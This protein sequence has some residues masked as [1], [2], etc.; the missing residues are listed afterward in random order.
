MSDLE[1]KFKENPEN[2]AVFRELEH[3][4]QSQSQWEKL[5]GIYRERAEF[6]KE[7]DMRDAAA[8][9][10]KAGR[11]YQHHLR[12]F[13]QAY[14]LLRQ[15]V[16]LDVENDEIFTAI[17]D[18]CT[19]T[20]RWQD[21]F[22][23]YCDRLE[24]VEDR[25]A[26][27]ELL[28][29][30]AYLCERHLKQA[31]QA[32]L[33]YSR[34]RELEP[35]NLEIL[36]QLAVL[37]EKQDQ[38]NSAIEVW[39]TLLKMADTSDTRDRINLQ[40]GALWEKL[41]DRGRA[42]S[43]YRS[44][45]GANLEEEAFARL[46]HIY[47][48]SPNDLAL[49]LTERLDSVEDKAEKAR[50][51]KKLAKLQQNREAAI[52][53]YQR[54]LEVGS[55]DI[56]VL[57]EISR[58][59]WEKGQVD[60]WLEY[61]LRIVQHL[62]STG[63]RVEL[64][65]E[66]AEKLRERSDCR[67]Q[68]IKIYEA[69]LAAAPQDR[70]AVEE[71][72]RL[73][74]E[75]HNHEALMKILV[76]KSKNC[77]LTERVSTYFQ[78]AKLLSE[79][80]NQQ[81]EAKS[82]LQKVLEIQEDH[83]PTLDE[84]KEQYL[85]EGKSAELLEVLRKK[86]EIEP[87]QAAQYHWEMGGI[88]RDRL[89]DA[90]NAIASFE[91]A[92]AADPRFWA[93]YEALLPLLQS[94]GQWK[95]YVSVGED[96][97]LILKDAQQAI[98]LHLSIA[99]IC[100]RQEEWQS[101]EEHLLM[102]LRY[103]PA[104]VHALEKLEALYFQ[105]QRWQNYVEV[106]EAKA[107]FLAKNEELSG[108][109][110]EIA[111]VYR[112]RL[113]QADSALHFYEKAHALDPFREEVLL[114]MQDLAQQIG[115]KHNL[116]YCLT[117]RSRLAS[118]AD[119][120]ASLLGQLG[121][122]FTQQNDMEQAVHAYEQ[123]LAKKNDNLDA[124]DN[125]I[126]LYHRQNQTEKIFHLL[127]RK[128]RLAQEQDQRIEMYRELARLAKELRRLP[129]AISYLEKILSLCPDHSQVLD[130]IAGLYLEERMWS[131]LLVVYR[132]KL[133]Q[134][135][136]E[137]KMDILRKMAAIY[138]EHVQ[139]L[140]ELRSVYREI[141]EIAPADLPTLHALQ[142]L[143]RKIEDWQGLIAACEEEVKVCGDEMKK[144]QIY[145]EMGKIYHNHLPELEKA[146][147][148]YTRALEYDADNYAV[149]KELHHLYLAQRDY[150]RAVE[151]IDRQL[152][153]LADPE[154]EA[155]LLV[156]KGTLYRDR[157]NDVQS[158]TKSFQEALGR[159]PTFLEPIAALET[160]FR[161]EQDYHALL[162]LLESKQ[163]VVDE[164]EDLH[165][166]LEIARIYA[167]HLQDEGNAEQ[168][169]LKA[170]RQK[171]SHQ[172][173]RERLVAFYS[174]RQNWESS[175]SLYHQQID[176]LPAGKDK[177][178]L[179]FLLGKLY[180]EK[181][182]NETQAAALY[183]QVLNMDQGN[184]AAIK[185]LQKIY[186]KENR[187]PSLTEAYLA[188]LAIPDIPLK[189]RIALHLT[190]AEIFHQ[191]LDRRD[192]AL[193]H[194]HQA[195]KLEPGNLSAIRH[196]E[197]LYREL[198]DYRALSQMLLT[199]LGI[200][201]NEKRLL[202]IHLDLAEL[203]LSHLK[204]P[205]EAIKHLAKAHTYRMQDEEILAKL[206]RVLYERE[207]WDQY[208]KYLMEELQ[209][210]K[211]TERQR[212]HLELAQIY[213]EKLQS[214]SKAIENLEA[215]ILADRVDTCYLRRLE[216]LYTKEG[217]TRNAAKLVQIYER[218]KSLTVDKTRLIEIY[219]QLGHL[220]GQE[221]GDLDKAC[222]C[223]EELLKLERD[224]RD[225]AEILAKIY[226]K[227]EKWE[228]LAQLL[229]HEAG[230]ATD[231]EKEKMLTKVGNI[232]EK[233]IKDYPKAIGYYQ[234]VL[235]L[236]RANLQALQGMRRLAEQ[237]KDWQTVLDLLY[238][239]TPLCSG[240]EQAAVYLKIA[241]LWESRFNL[242]H[243]AVQSYLEMLKIHFYHP[244][245]EYVLSLLTSIKDYKTF[246][247][248]SQKVIKRTKDPLQK[249]DRLCEL[250][251]VLFYELKEPAQAV[252][253][254][255]KAI[256]YSPKKIDA[257]S[258]L[259]EIYESRQQ[260]QEL[261]SCKERKLELTNN[262]TEIRKLHWDLGKI[263]QERLFDE[264]KA[265]FHYE[266]VLEL[267]P[268]EV[269][270][271]H[272]L[273]QLYLAWGY[274]DRYIQLC[275]REM[276]IT[277]DRERHIHL[278]S[279]I[280]RSWEEKLY[281]EE[282]AIQSY[283][284]LL[285]FDPENLHAVNHLIPLYTKTESYG[286]LISVYEVPLKEARQK[287]DRG[288]VIALQLT[289]AK[290]L[291]DRLSM[292]AEAEKVWK[293]VLELDPENQEALAALTTMFRQTRDIGQLTQVLTMK[294]QLSQDLAEK[295]GLYYQLGKFYEEEAGSL[296][297]AI[298]AYQQA[299][300]IEPQK[301]EILR[302]LQKLY[303][304]TDNLRA[305]INVDE[306]LASLTD[307]TNERVALYWEI[308]TLLK[309][310]PE[311]AA[312]YLEKILTIDN[313]HL[314]A[315]SFLSDLLEKQ[316]K[317]AGMEQVM[318]SW[319]ASERD[320]RKQS[321]LLVKRGHIYQNFLDD[322]G[323]ALS[324][325]ELALQKDHTYLPALTSLADLYWKLANWEKA[326][327]LYEQ[328]VRWPGPEQL[329]ALADEKEIFYRWA[330]AAENLRKSEIAV[331]RYQKILEHSPQHLAALKSLG[332]IYYCNQQ[333]EQALLIYV[334]LNGLDLTE[335]EQAEVR[336]LLSIIK[337]KMGMT[338]GAIEGYLHVLEE[339]REDAMA[340]QAL[341]T[342][343]WER[344]EEE[345]ALEYF[346]KLKDTA[347]DPELKKTA[348]LWMGKICEA[349]D[350]IG[351][352][353]EYYRELTSGETPDKAALQQLVKLYLKQ[354]DWDGASACAGRLYPLLS[355]DLER[356][357]MDVIRGNIRFS[358]YRDQAG[359][360]AEYEAALRKIPAYLPAI[361]A[362]SGI[363][364]ELGDWGG[365][366][367]TYQQC[368]ERFPEEA[369]AQKIPLL[370]EQAQIHE[371]LGQIQ[372]EIAAYEAI[373]EIDP[374]HPASHVALSTLWARYP[375]KRTD[376]ITEHHYL[377]TQD[378]FRVVS[379]HEL[380]RLYMEQKD[381]DRCYLC[382]QAL[383]ALDKI[384]PEESQFLERVPPRVPSGWLDSWTL[385]Q[386]L[387]ENDRS[388]LYEIM[389]SVDPYTV[390]AY[391]PSLE[392]KYNVRRKDRVSAS[393]DQYIGSAVNDLMRLLGI[394]DFALYLSDADIVA[395]ENTQPPSLI[396]GRNLLSGWNP[397]Q[398]R[399]VV[400]HYLFYVSRNHTMAAKLSPEEYQKYVFHL[401]EG[402]AETGKKLSPEEEAVSRKLRF[403]LPRKIR[404]QLEE[405]MDILT[406]IYHADLT[407]FLKSLQTAA[408][409]CGL[410]FCDSLKD[411]LTA[412]LF[413]KDRKLHALP[414][415][416]SE[417]KE[418]REL[419]WFNMSNEYQRLRAE[420]GIII[421]WIR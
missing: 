143:C 297:K 195:V 133:A 206:K 250:G 328:L 375:E 99:E 203:F 301:I 98:A 364:K 52:A 344:K 158:A 369:R 382:C 217:T 268:K 9:F 256:K 10:L 367:K 125:L 287:E 63:H 264:K 293:E 317:W 385:D 36:N 108:R 95:R 214:P 341:G 160:I 124:I 271:I 35:K 70:L 174:K 3:L 315:L 154:L 200:E 168:Y 117:M 172:E 407:S 72:T 355:S 299:H 379:Y 247:E 56:E 163:V 220:Y 366:I 262:K 101:A 291:W 372:E 340:L 359:A 377:L 363:Y 187:F 272:T 4:Y 39:Q 190:C 216:D 181:L 329:K 156:E 211:A 80:L 394:G 405:R 380:F 38:W 282:Q 374:E 417:I 12:D 300:A 140:W 6:L 146:I 17:E 8:L 370:L 212:L 102:V 28:K 226:T 277:E 159:C 34:A 257:I 383:K 161:Q 343:Y 273:Q 42:S 41:G 53:F 419:F 392:E 321:K 324:D 147:L 404:R 199:E 292:R 411:A 302:D 294:I 338:E 215:A 202:L 153:L 26:R 2:T 15:A 65:R 235:M 288:K 227:L 27:L 104:H 323:K 62:D 331:L 360:F 186:E 224:R 144:T 213:E 322:N 278:L 116:I 279:E 342:L 177:A 239:E 93:A 110:F 261:A 298:D 311:K 358:G 362:M 304:R 368:I 252:A 131:P 248:L 353:I 285:K 415:N 44:V 330:K 167:D 310:T 313:T 381:Y 207:H 225:V 386:L 94:K 170:A 402:F 1:D 237:Q 281:N 234:M 409:K 335:Q 384:V 60:V 233:K 397:A 175:R 185:S 197:I 365:V 198:G 412:H 309:D 350:D 339:N 312:S 18:C 393:A 152:K 347:K 389:A 166:L 290:I 201:K 416:L 96:G 54:A 83:H 390:K 176:A 249:A 255:E 406:E 396:V 253:A 135:R 296:D 395:L 351:Q 86:I 55:E 354:R 349:L 74:R 21:L 97:L 173:A 57:A 149:L 7:V 150:P 352:A 205:E 188:E 40:L 316:Q 270:A 178:H 128:T 400:G 25:K 327:P 245:A 123:A 89:Q 289:R 388:T 171:P 219:R 13:N 280:A 155:H 136:P 162:K 196:L 100:G 346:R 387:Q 64:L 332:N 334:K 107:R 20:R 111:R 71:L 361:T 246:C 222:R 333:W 165:L 91:K 24:V 326:E 23:I 141:L 269:F 192:W 49:L 182:A 138:E 30:T 46:E 121:K 243:Q 251:R 112:D 408:N 47:L 274:F 266:R 129:A 22:Q 378:P 218:E 307:Q 119:Q 306:Q 345:K 58:I 5:A 137:G 238:Q 244:T 420:L 303:R 210:C 398:I 254:Y 85:K 126:E 142:A 157:L 267:T 318:G 61:Q 204:D 410:L 241:K 79:S 189:R 371:S 43:Y 32:I 236:N 258:G 221:P 191:N 183:V 67:S 286:K 113:K 184:L 33:L 242:I 164:E 29:K 130:D 259:E 92:I 232:C 223:W 337:D 319:I 169:L 357:E 314:E 228:K 308:A 399:F 84:L 373:L 122:I 69:L 82:Y 265:I 401:V 31:D 45:T 50:M 14:P 68:L 193:T 356:A 336:L 81:E 179:M 109:Y 77:S 78:I 59:F 391:I 148:C 376:A 115:D 76:H 275:Q 320:P 413:L 132:R 145:E 305:L 134:N 105:Q 403:A 209:Q 325:F 208:I 139:D 231:T 19:E 11:A 103:D 90:E 194:Y 120:C 180:E 240:N 114:E 73:Y 118:S 295:A 418:A 260:W 283:E 414:E 106:L 75:E 48:G 348:L 276:K 37:F 151:M 230:I 284:E 66:S 51:Y 421:K 87:G 16:D 229:L 127:E 263:A 88:Y